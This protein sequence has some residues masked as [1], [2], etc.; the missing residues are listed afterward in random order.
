MHSM[1]LFKDE[2]DK[3]MDSHSH[4]TKKLH[5][6][7]ALIIWTHG[8]AFVSFKRSFHFQS[9]I[10]VVFEEIFLKSSWIKVK[11]KA[12]FV[13]EKISLSYVF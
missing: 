7:N 12:M 11:T 1:S 2:F 13:T 8:F 6:Y 9:M 10:A 5:K 4:D 3:T